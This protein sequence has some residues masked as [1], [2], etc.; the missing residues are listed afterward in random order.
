MKAGLHDQVPDVP[1]PPIVNV[2][3]DVGGELLAVNEMA[4]PSGSFAE[5]VNVISE[6][7]APETVAG[8]VTVGGR[9]VFVTVIA[10][11]AEPMWAFDAVNVTV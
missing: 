7:S 6:P 8:A 4:S 9:S 10:V 1:P 5:T 2:L 11:F 3:P